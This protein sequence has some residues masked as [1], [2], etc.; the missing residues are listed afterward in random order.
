[1]DDKSHSILKLQCLL[2]F[3]KIKRNLRG[4]KDKYGINKTNHF[5]DNRG[6]GNLYCFNNS[7]R[8]ERHLTQLHVA[9]AS[10]TTLEQLPLIFLTI[11]TLTL[12]H[13]C[14]FQC[15]KTN[16]LYL[17]P[18]HIF[19]TIITPSLKT[20]NNTLVFSCFDDLLWKDHIIY[21]T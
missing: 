10:M 16:P 9:S 18:R 15:L 19:H 8:Y 7:F 13:C 2:L 4:S 12:K 1:M 6:R 21:L 5:S 20:Q 14:G 17:S 11:L 3:I